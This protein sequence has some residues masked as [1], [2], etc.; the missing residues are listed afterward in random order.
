MDDCTPPLKHCPHCHTDKPIDAFSKNKSKNDGRAT[1]CKMCTAAYRAANRDKFAA[2]QIA[3]RNHHKDKMDASQTK[4]RSKHQKELTAYHAAWVTKNRDAVSVHQRHYRQRHPDQIRANTHRRRAIKKA[5][6]GTHNAIDIRRQGE[7]QKWRCWWCGEDCKDNYHIDHLVPLARGGHND[8]GNIV[9][10]CP[11][12][13]MSKNDK[14]P[15][16]WCGRLL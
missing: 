11:Y 1:Q 15:D 9:I 16:E 14:L 7:V 10:A 5:V 3:Y 2:R 8:P 12:C 4:W 13:N 6:G